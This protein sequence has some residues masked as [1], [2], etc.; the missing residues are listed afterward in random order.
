MKELW[1]SDSLS[2][3]RMIVG[4]KRSEIKKGYIKTPRE[5]R[6]C[7]ECM[8]EKQKKTPLVNKQSCSQIPKNLK[9]C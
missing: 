3:Q 5:K 2:R 8:E 6:T 7:E 1:A 9:L 4:L